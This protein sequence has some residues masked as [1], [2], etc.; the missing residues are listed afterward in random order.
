MLF[1]QRSKKNKELPDAK[2]DP[3]KRKD[4]DEKNKLFPFKKDPTIIN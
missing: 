3:I 1:K 4:S 2:K